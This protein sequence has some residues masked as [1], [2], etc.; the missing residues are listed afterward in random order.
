MF[1]FSQF[2]T[3]GVGGARRPSSSCPGAAGQFLAE[4]RR[5]SVPGPQVLTSCGRGAPALARSAFP[6]CR[7]FSASEFSGLGRAAFAAR[8]ALMVRSLASQP[9]PLWVC[10]PGVSCPPGV[11]PSR[12][13]A[14]C[15]S[16]SWS[17]CSLA[18][19]LGCA[20][21]V[22]L[23]SGVVPPRSFGAWS[24]V[25]ASAGGAWWFRAAPAPQASLF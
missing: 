8:A 2:L 23:P 4:L 12:R 24:P 15:G 7:L 11:A 17:E 1:D 10:F 25:S 21:L 22:F 16:G 19:G 14:P 18:A 3:F 6:A 13:W 9:S 5:L 20:V